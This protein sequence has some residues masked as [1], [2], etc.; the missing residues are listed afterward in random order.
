MPELVRGHAP[1]P[2]RAGGVRDRVADALV[3]DPSAAVDEQPRLAQAGRAVGDPLVEQLLELRVQRDVAVG[4]Q[5]PERHV[6]PVRGADLHDRVDRQI[7]ELAAP[8]PGAGEELDR[9]PGERVGSLA[10]GAQQL[11]RGAVVDEPRQ[12][13]IAARDVTGE[14]Q[15]T[16]GS[17]LA[18][19]FAEALQA[20]PQRAEMLAS[21]VLRQSPAAQVGLCARWRL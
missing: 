19:P 15:H 18:V 2:G 6:Q 9:E 11:L 21:H 17:V 1:D 13:V 20:H 14:H 7:E 16:G 4:A 8:K 3:A 12:R 5:L 10:R